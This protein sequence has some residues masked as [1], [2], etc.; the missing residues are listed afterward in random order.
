MARAR[1]T[2]QFDDG[3]IIIVCEVGSDAEH[4][5]ALDGLVR[6]CLELSAEAVPV[7]GES[8]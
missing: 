8:D 7:E 3:N 5:D 1:I 2:H 6:R 4:P